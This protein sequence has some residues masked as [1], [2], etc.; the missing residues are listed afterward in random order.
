MRFSSDTLKPFVLSHTIVSY[1]GKIHAN[2]YFHTRQHSF[3][4]L[5][6]LF[7]TFTHALSYFYTRSTQ[8]SLIR[9]NAYRLFFLLN[10]IFN[11]YLTPKPVDNSVFNL[12]KIIQI[13][14]TALLFALGITILRGTPE[15]IRS[16]NGA[17]FIA[18]RAWVG[19]IGAKTAFIT[20]GS[21][22]E[23]G[24]CESSTPASAM[25]CSMG[26]SSTRY[27]RLRS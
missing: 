27:A 13:E 20:P 5:H 6:T 15:F 21:P 2:S 11:T 25:S 23:N 1:R 18:K 19:A 7:R 8:N 9:S 10:T 16:D 3:V 24:Y 12:S 14:H 17:E 22:W 26:R 4:L